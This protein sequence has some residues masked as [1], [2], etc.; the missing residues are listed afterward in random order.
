MM[1]TPEFKERVKRLEVNPFQ[2]IEEF[3]KGRAK[4]E[5]AIRAYSSY[6]RDTELE[7]LEL[8]CLAQYPDLL[9]ASTAH[10]VEGEPRI[11]V[12]SPFPLSEPYVDGPKVFEVFIKNIVTLN[13]IVEEGM[14]MPED[15]VQGNP[16]K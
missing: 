16:P 6:L 11:Y 10:K 7:L 8:T 9:R 3:D 5:D 12:T 15:L 1:T 13:A 2:W 4:L 14:A